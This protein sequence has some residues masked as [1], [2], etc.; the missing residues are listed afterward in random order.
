MG[1]E[2]I[3][4]RAT[5]RD[6]IIAGLVGSLTIWLYEVVVFVGVQHADTVASVV[7]HTALL[8]FGPA[9]LRHAAAAFGLGLV[10]HCLTGIVWGVGF[11]AIWPRLRQQGIEASLAALVYGA[12]VWVCMHLGIL[13]LLS[14]DPPIYTAP[15]VISGLMSHMVAFAVP[16]ALTV[17]R[18]FSNRKVG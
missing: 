2:L 4:T 11:A 6:G 12:F 14:P 5:W 3:P 7:R 15:T 17:Q 8:V 10:I 18:L 1:Q 16:V 13:A 9:I